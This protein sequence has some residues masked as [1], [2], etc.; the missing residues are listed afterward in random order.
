M[1]DLNAAAQLKFHHRR[2]PPKSETLGGTHYIVNKLRRNLIGFILT[3]TEHA[4]A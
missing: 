3:V 2:L 4:R 1:S